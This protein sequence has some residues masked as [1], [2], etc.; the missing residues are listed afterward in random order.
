[1]PMCQRR[2]GNDSGVQAATRKSRQ[3]RAK[4]VA[5]GADTLRRLNR[6]NTVLAGSKSPHSPQATR[7]FRPKPGG[8]AVDTCLLRS[9]RFGIVMPDTSAAF[10]ITRH[11]RRALKRQ[12][13]AQLHAA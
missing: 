13:H 9:K 7:N 3:V 10:D 11:R 6:M 1:M 4:S 2:P 5:K 8:V 12:E